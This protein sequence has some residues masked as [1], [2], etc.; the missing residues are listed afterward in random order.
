MKKNK[1]FIYRLYL[2]IRKKISTV[3][4]FKSLRKVSNWAEWTEIDKLFGELSTDPYFK[5]FR[6]HR[7]I[8][9]TMDYQGF[10][11]MKYS[12]SLSRIGVKESMIGRPFRPLFLKNSLNLGHQYKH[13]LNWFEAIGTD[14]SSINRIIEF[15]GGFGSMRWLVHELGFKK[16]YVIVDNEGIKQLQLRYI[17]ES[18]GEEIFRQTVWKNSNELMDLNLNDLFVALWSLSETPEVMMQMI[19]KEVNN[20]GSH[21]L[22]AYQHNFHGR[23]NSAFFESKFTSAVEKPVIGL[24]DG[25]AST[26][27][28]R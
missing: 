13:L 16:N 19:I 28:F 23:N 10:A 14:L 18:L 4:Y 24:S 27:I 6:R 3:I 20:S 1:E 15:G 22:I 11:S 9:Q 5:N 2:K 7:L 26:Y 8:I 25:S 21:L 17:K 12:K